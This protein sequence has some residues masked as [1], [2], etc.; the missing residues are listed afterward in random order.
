M[1][2]AELKAALAAVADPEYAVG[3]ARYFRTGPGEYGEGDVFIGVRVPMNR[4]VAKQFGN[5]DK[6][7]TDEL[8]GSEIHEHRLAALFILVRQFEVATR[9]GDVETQQRIVGDYL[10]ALDRNE[11]N[12]WDLVDS[13]APKIL[14]RWLRDKSP[15]L[16]FELAERP[17][18]WDRRVAVL[19]SFAFIDAGESAVTIRLA[20]KLLSD[21]RDL[22][23]KAVGWSLREL[24]KR[25]GTEV[26]LA[27]LAAHAADMGRTALSY[28][29]E[30]LEPG[31]RARLRAL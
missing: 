30:H 27:F 4:S 8:L 28:A 22:I 23:Q 31:V 20:E 14:G 29:T 11:I 3:A 2:A 17:G 9:R 25:V 19:A 15:D 7:G 12:N 6:A 10:A 18:L 26:L 13:S 1:S 5:L 16:L 21:L 24:G